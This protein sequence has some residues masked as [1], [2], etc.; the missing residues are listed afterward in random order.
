MT[1]VGFNLTSIKAERTKPI[2]GKIN[3]KNN[4]KIDEIKESQLMVGKQKQKTLIFEFS[5][6]S[7]YS[8]NMGGVEIKGSLVY[9]TDVKTIDEIVKNW[10]GG[11]GKSVPEDIMA[12]VLNTVLNKCSIMALQMSKEVNLPPQIQLPKVKVN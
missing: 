12:P 7:K 8:P 4:V 6:L 3:V 9:L 1:I 2:E 5:Y 10:K 11:K